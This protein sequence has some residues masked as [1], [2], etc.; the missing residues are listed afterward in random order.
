ME[1]NVIN[2]KDKQLEQFLISICA[3]I[4]DAVEMTQNAKAYYAGLEA[5]L[6][7]TNLEL[8]EFYLSMDEINK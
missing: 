5:K 4:A 8:E 7:Q 6:I 2:L 1:S 3:R